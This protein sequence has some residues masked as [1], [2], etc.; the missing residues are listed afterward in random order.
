MS[1]ALPLP[2]RPNPDQYKKLARDLQQACKSG[3]PGAIRAWAIRWLQ[4]L[5]QLQDTAY[6]LTRADARTSPSPDLQP[7]IERE[8]GRIDRRWHEFNA[9]GDRKSACRLA[10]AQFFIAR[11][12]GFASWPRFAAHLA[13]LSESSS[14]VAAF[15]SAADAIVS[16]DI[17][18]LA[19]LLRRHPD[20][21]RARS[22][23]DHRSTLLHYV[24]ANG[25][26]DFRQKTPGNIV[27][28][29]K[30][31]LQAGADVDAESEAYGGGS[32][33]L[34]LTATSVH[35]EHAGVQI[36]LLETLLAHGAHIEKPGLTGNRSAAVKGCLANGQGRAAQFFA[37][38][39]ARMDL[40]EAAG[41][42]R[43]DVVK[44]FFDEHGAV[45]P[46]AT[47]EQ[48]DSGFMYAA[49]YGHLDI[50]QFL[51]DRGVDPGVRNKA[52]QTA[53]HWTTYGPHVEIARLLLTERGS[54]VDAKETAFGG[55]PLDW[56]LRAS[57]NFT[58]EADRE[59]AYEMVALLVRAGGKATARWLDKSA[60]DMLAADERMQKTL[61]LGG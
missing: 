12:H 11:E 61:G 46:P 57:A 9:S 39:G 55:T 47:R 18:R 24:S 32:T 27:E 37:E 56:A 26:E 41:V 35:P 22:T 19:G 13:T 21:V 8:A 3:D 10:D 30:L 42:G 20:L 4:A 44:R 14:P 31:L 49:G 7:A 45:A 28:I 33:T 51:L 38:R 53:L 43:L 58:R 36:A 60:A 23:R 52:G 17:D 5:A 29:A 2:P 6:K 50:V 1:D 25:V 48:L 40:E 16:G 15:E 34:G 54:L 59:R